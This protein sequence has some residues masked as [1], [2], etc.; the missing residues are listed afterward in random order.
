MEERT[1]HS[2]CRKGAR[3]RVQRIKSEER[4]QQ[5]QSWEVQRGGVVIREETAG[6]ELDGVL[7]TPQC[8]KAS[9]APLR[10]VGEQRPSL[11]LL[12]R[13]R[14]SQLSAFNP[15]KCSSWTSKGLGAHEE[16]ISDTALLSLFTAR[17]TLW[18]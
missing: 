12:H 11:G 9:R 17:G 18:Q 2:Y 5:G 3:H 14:A 13:L 8:P 1:N 16:W 7:L 4:N 15:S 6:K 10:K